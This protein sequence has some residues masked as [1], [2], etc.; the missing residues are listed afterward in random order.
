[1]Q[2]RIRRKAQ[3]EREITNWSQAKDGGHVDRVLSNVERDSLKDAVAYLAPAMG[4]LIR[5]STYKENEGSQL[6]LQWLNIAKFNQI[7]HINYG[8]CFW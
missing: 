4:Q 5:P 1:M 3:T 2:G 6:T 8:L 7:Y